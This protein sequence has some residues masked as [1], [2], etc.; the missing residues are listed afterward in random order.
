M[1]PLVKK[2]LPDSNI[3]KIRQPDNRLFGRIN[4]FYKTV[5]QINILKI[6]LQLRVVKAHIL[7]KPH[8][9]P[10]LQ[11][12]NL[13]LDKNN[14]LKAGITPALNDNPYKTHP[15]SLPTSLLHPSLVKAHPPQAIHPYV[16][17]LTPLQDL[18]QAAQPDRQDLNLAERRQGE[19]SCVVGFFHWTV[20]WQGATERD[21]R[22][23]FGS[24]DGAADCGSI[25][26]DEGDEQRFPWEEAFEGVQWGLAVEDL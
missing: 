8:K 15:N 18:T 25:A 17:R 11:D 2:E 1:V 21:T 14:S 23:V 16:T 10:R 9:E 22:C 24:L 5:I 6:R 4:P 13:R 19:R 26:Y 12:E 7:D 3:Y 20:H